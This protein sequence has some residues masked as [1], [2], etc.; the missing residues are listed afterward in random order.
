MV[1]IHG[2]GF[3]KG[4]ADESLYGPDYL[5]QRNV[6]FV[7][8]N[9]RLG[10]LGFLSIADP[11]V[12]VPGNAGLKD[13]SLALRWVRQNIQRFGGDAQNVTIF[14]ESAGGS[15]V[16][17]HMVSEL[18]RGLFDRAIVQSASALCPW[19]HYPN[20]NWA[21]RLATK[22]GWTGEGGSRGAYDFLREA[23]A[24][25]IVRSQDDLVD[26]A[27]K[28]VGIATFGPVSE[29]YRS[30]Q[31]FIAGNIEELVRNPWSRHVPLLIG[32]N[33]DE[34]L[35][36][37]RMFN[38]NAAFLQSPSGVAAL[39]PSEVVRAKGPTVL[40]RVL[41]YYY[42]DTE[43]PAT[44]DNLGPLVQMWGD[45]NFWHGIYA[46][47]AARLLDNSKHDDGAAA[48]AATYL[49]R[50]AKDSRTMCQLKHALMGVDMPGVC[51]GEDILYLFKPHMVEDVPATE[52]LTIERMTDIWTHFAKTGNPT[53]AEAIASLNWPALSAANGYRGL[54]I[55]D[56]MTVGELAETDRVQFWNS[57]LAL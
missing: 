16:H 38:A 14:G 2:G 39:V 15:S 33:S 44:P 22:L 57:I 17:F 53:T 40:Q 48:A 55:N 54:N 1:W 20:N 34:G 21:R 56:E 46:A 43:A 29:P 3:K 12:A 26:V 27:E 28:M 13:Q 10:A 49:Y 23:D 50:F 9:Y 25:D 4:S 47:A 42:R 45:R 52:Q 6:V 11:S 36:F 35:L 41:D 37:W 30:E 24:A 8:V 51:H 7:S 19:N 5:L 18:S 31:T 32:G